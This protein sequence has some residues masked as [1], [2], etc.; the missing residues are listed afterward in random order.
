[1][2]FRSGLSGRPYGWDGTGAGVILNGRLFR[3]HSHAAG[4]IGW[5][6]NELLSGRKFPRLGRSKDLNYGPGMAQKVVF[7]TLETIDAE[8]LAGN[9]DVKELSDPSMLRGNSSLLLVHDMIDYLTLAVATLCTVLN[10]PTV[11]LAGDISRGA[12]P[13]ADRL[14]DRLAGQLPSVPRIFVSELGYRAVALGAIMT[15]LDATTLNKAMAF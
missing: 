3:G 8:F 12:E 5:L 10:P 6:H 9:F 11:I 4:E 2:G 7:D 14:R 15:V 1:M 13:V